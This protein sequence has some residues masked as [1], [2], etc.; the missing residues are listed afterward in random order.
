MLVIVSITS[1]L[2]A[3]F[4]LRACGVLA[5]VC[6]NEGSRWRS[7]ATTFHDNYYKNWNYNPNITKNVKWYIN[8]IIV[9]IL[10]F[11]QHGT[12]YIIQLEIT[13][14][15][16]NTIVM[17]RMLKFDECGPCNEGATNIFIGFLIW[18]LRV[19]PKPTRQPFN[20]DSSSLG[21]E[22]LRITTK[23]WSFCL[24]SLNYDM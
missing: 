4:L 12:V 24:F 3:C 15:S 18:S 2:C 21:A 13:H 6:G 22:Q 7:R 1:A 5:V 17:T 11:L 16:Y 8:Y 9:Y 20:I 10:H 19:S 23:G 14:P